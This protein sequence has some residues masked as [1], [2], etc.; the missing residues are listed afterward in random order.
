MSHCMKSEKL[1]WTRQDN[2]KIICL[3]ELFFHILLKRVFWFFFLSTGRPPFNSG[4][5][6]VWT[7]LD[8]K[9]QYLFLRFGSNLLRGFF[10]HA[11]Q[12]S[13]VALEVFLGWYY[14][15]THFHQV[16][17]YCRGNLGCGCQQEI[18]LP[19]HFCCLF[20]IKWNHSLNNVDNSH[21]SLKM[22]HDVCVSIAMLKCP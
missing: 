16:N 20:S 7:E 14:L 22:F 12:D 11:C 13:K 21:S 19:T 9:V 2:K 6:F 15:H 10:S 8:L 1:R 3:N 4:L 17:V 5:V 18:Q